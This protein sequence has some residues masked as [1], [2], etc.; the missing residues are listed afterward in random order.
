MH[1]GAD[2][3]LQ[4][5]TL[6]YGLTSSSLAYS[7]ISQ[8]RSAS[9]RA[10]NR[11]LAND[12]SVEVLSSYRKLFSDSEDLE[13]RGF[14]V[15]HQIVLDLHNRDARTYLRTCS[16]TEIDQGDM[17]GYTP[18]HW[19]A[20]RGDFEMVSLLLQ[21]GADPNIPGNRGVYALHF[22]S[23]RKSVRCIDQM[24]RYRTDVN[25]RDSMQITPLLHM[26][27]Y[28]QPD[29]VCAKRLIE[30]GAMVDA[31]DCQGA[32]PLMFVSRYNSIP[33]LQLL[34]EHGAAIDHQTFSAETALTL[35]FQANAHGT[36]SIL[37]AHGASVQQLTV[38]GRS[39]LHEAAECDDEET[40]RILTAAHIYG[41]D[42]KGKSSDGHTPWDL[43]R[44]R[45]DVTPE[46]RAAF[47]TF[48]ESVEE[49]NANVS[50]ESNRGSSTNQAHTSWKRAF[51]KL[52]R[53]IKDIF[54]RL[55]LHV[56]QLVAQLLGRHI[57]VTS[58]SLVF[59]ALAWYLFS[60]SGKER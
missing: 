41:I 48:L 53:M 29:L 56:H 45:D 12:G 39:I 46:W 55:I 1:E 42:I 50:P 18:L 4:I 26:C 30:K 38:S 13:E 5:G 22:A 60:E 9:K 33:M 23:K 25:A 40:L 11:I 15:L 58:V 34:L 27:Y 52:P 51:N 49:N 10:W 19:A 7:L 3:Y 21:E 16:R 35:A 36:M 17:Q 31:L 8:Y 43:A 59:A 54:C 20:R 24:L 2:P 14:T 44:K 57:L 32:T 37:L 47:L 6:Q 28:P